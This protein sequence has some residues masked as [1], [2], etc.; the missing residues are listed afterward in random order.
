MQTVSSATQFE[1]VNCWQLAAA[2]LVLNQ[3]ALFSR[4][5]L[6]HF[7]FTIHRNPIPQLSIKQLCQPSA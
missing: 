1:L 6:I 7:Q 4:F 2:N 5:Y 3:L